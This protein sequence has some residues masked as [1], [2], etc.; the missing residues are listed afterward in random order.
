MTSPNYTK[1][2]FKSLEMKSIMNSN[3]MKSYA[4]LLQ[5]SD[6]NLNEMS[7]KFTKAKQ[8]VV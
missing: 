3:V 6:V 5:T 7:I 2:Y 8:Q 1:H 4:H